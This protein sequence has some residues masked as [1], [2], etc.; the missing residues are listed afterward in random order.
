MDARSH[1]DGARTPS[2]VDKGGGGG[3]KPNEN[4]PMKLGE[5]STQL[6]LL[7]EDILGFVSTLICIF[8]RSLYVPLLG[9]QGIFQCIYI[10]V[11]C[12]VKKWNQFRAIGVVDGLDGNKD[13]ARLGKQA[14]LQSNATGPFKWVKENDKKTMVYFIDLARK[15][16]DEDIFSVEKPDSE[17]FT[18]MITGMQEEM[19]NDELW[20]KIKAQMLKEAT[21]E[22]NR[23]KAHEDLNLTRNDGDIITQKVTFNF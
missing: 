6:K 9:M 13:Q 19:V 4:D 23:N 16:S 11:Q 21:E 14:I 18:R 10:A 15:K 1:S 7:T 12:A 5:F 8:Y 17:G 3:L 2:D 22:Q 20:N